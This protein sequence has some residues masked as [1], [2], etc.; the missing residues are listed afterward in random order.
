M[1][2]EE[3]N[4]ALQDEENAPLACEK[5]EKEEPKEKKCSKKE[6]SKIQKEQRLW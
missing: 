4:E 1:N 5:E 2:T 6:L 3:K